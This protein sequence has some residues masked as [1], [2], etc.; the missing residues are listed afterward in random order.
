MLAEKYINIHLKATC[1]EDAVQP[2][3]AA[4]QA[5]KKEGLF[6]SI[7]SNVKAVAKEVIDPNVSR[8][9]CK[10]ELVE[11]PE[12]AE[13]YTEVTRT[14]GKRAHLKVIWKLRNAN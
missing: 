1:E 14:E 4:N 5:N 8:Y 6:K 2:Q 9:L 7:F 13:V 10:V 11:S 3:P 12:F